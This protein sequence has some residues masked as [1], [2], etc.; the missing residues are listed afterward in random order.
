[1]PCAKQSLLELLLGVSL[2][3]LVAG[4]LVLGR[5][6]VAASSSHRLLCF[7]DVCSLVHLGDV[8]CV[9]GLRVRTQTWLSVYDQ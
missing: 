2:R 4:L 9:L 1:M 6:N 8:R 5:D 3:L 7:V